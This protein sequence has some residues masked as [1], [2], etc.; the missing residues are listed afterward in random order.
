[1]RSIQE[2]GKHDKRGN[3]VPPPYVV[4]VHAD[5]IVG[6]STLREN[7]A[8]A[9]IVTTP[10]CNDNE[11][12]KLRRSLAR[13]ATER[14]WMIKPK[15][16][17][18]PGEQSGGLRE[19]TLSFRSHPLRRH[20]GVADDKAPGPV[21]RLGDADRGV[22]A[23]GSASAASRRQAGRLGDPE[24]GPSRSRRHRRW[25]GPAPGRAA[26]A[27]RQIADGDA[28]AAPL[29]HQLDALR[30]ESRGSAQLPPRPPLRHHI[31]ARV[32][33]IRAVDVGVSGGPNMIGCASSGHDRRAPRGQSPRYTPPSRR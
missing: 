18:L 14:G 5:P 30:A 7:L 8:H 25:S 19:K 11:F 22:V 3:L 31:Q 24:A 32:H 28:F 29:P 10:D 21:G 12:K 6:D 16:L 1:M 2:V 4:D 9:I 13:H 15:E 33:A 20:I 17:R 26:R 27:A 23:M